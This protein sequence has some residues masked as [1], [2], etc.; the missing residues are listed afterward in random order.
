LQSDTNYK[1]TGNYDG[2]HP[3]RHSKGIIQQRAKH[4]FDFAGA[5][6][7]ESAPTH[8]NYVIQYP[9][10]NRR[11]KR[12]EDVAA[13]SGRYSK[14]IKVFVSRGQYFERFRYACA[15]CAACR[16]FHGNQGN[17][18]DNQKSQINENERASTVFAGYVWEPPNVA[19]S[20]GASGGDKDETKPGTKIFSLHFPFAP[21]FIFW[22]SNVWDIKNPF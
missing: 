11:I 5:H 19:Q 3:Q 13:Q 15:A 12:H 10:A 16:V 1:E 21:S 7:D 17:P 20:D 2:N 22:Y 4:P 18:D 6:P 9:S 8:L 14:P